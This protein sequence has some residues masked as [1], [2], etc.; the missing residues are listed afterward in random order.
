MWL[1]KYMRLEFQ[2]IPTLKELEHSAVNTKTRNITQYHE[3]V[4]KTKSLN[5]WDTFPSSMSVLIYLS[6][7]NLAQMNPAFH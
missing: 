1:Y 6:Q 7:M 2:E 4:K 3:K 5:I